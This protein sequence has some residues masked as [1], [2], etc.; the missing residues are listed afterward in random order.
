MRQYE[1]E[2]VEGSYPV[3]RRDVALATLERHQFEDVSLDRKGRNSVAHRHVVVVA[4]TGH[5][6][7]HDHADEQ[8]S[9]EASINTVRKR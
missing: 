2:R 9:E 3:K 6:G 1:H 7:Q 4:H 8:R 5:N